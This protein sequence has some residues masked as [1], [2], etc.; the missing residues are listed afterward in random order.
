[1]AP[2]IQPA[3]GAPAARPLLVG[4]VARDLRGGVDVC[5]VARAV[6]EIAAQPRR[7]RKGKPGLDLGDLYGRLEQERDDVR[8]P[9]LGASPD[10]GFDISLDS[11]ADLE[12]A[13]PSARCSR[14]WPDR[15]AW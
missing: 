2:Q 15:S 1:M 9:V 13:P 5:F 4:Q 8:G 7:L 11:A 12:R 3:E 10:V 14:I 6:L